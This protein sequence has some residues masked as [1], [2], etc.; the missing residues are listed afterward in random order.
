MPEPQ[1]TLVHV[2]PGRRG[3]RPRLRARPADPGRH[4]RVRRRGARR[5]SR[6]TAPAWRE[7]TERAHEQYLACARAASRRPAPC[8]S[9][10][11]C[12]WLREHLPDDA[13]VTNGAGNYCVWVNG[14]Y[15]YRRLPHAARRRPAA[16]WAT[17]CRPR[18]PPSWSI[19]SA[20]WSC[21]A[22]DGCFLMTGQELA[23]AVQYDAAGDLASSSTTACTARSA[24][25]RSAT[26]P[27]RV[28]GTDLQEPGFRR[29]RA[30]L[31]RPRRDGR[32]HRRFRR[33]LPPRR[34]GRHASR[35]STCGSTRR[36]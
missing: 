16:R 9:A 17:A 21:F 27:S 29:A 11:S 34:A 14:Y 25:T 6:S 1:Q 12:V 22:G 28:V 36:R 2:H 24:C 26:I 30:R 20:P 35:C 23:T 19:P 15:Q 5:S 8:S 32:A 3:A 7:Q 18:S 33:R 31:R 10:R 13:I 4:A